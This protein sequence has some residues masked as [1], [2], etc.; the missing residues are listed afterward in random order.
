MAMPLT[1]V[2]GAGTSCA[3]AVSTSAAA[4]ECAFAPAVVARL[5]LL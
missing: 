3:V 5:L 2:A 1:A 4:T